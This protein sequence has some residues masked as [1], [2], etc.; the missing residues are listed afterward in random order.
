MKFDN[1][2]S[3]IKKVKTKKITISKWII[4]NQK[5]LKS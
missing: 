2:L 1:I 3:L 4:G 5:P